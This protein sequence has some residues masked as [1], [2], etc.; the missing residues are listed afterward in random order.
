M[1]VVQIDVDKFLQRRKRIP[2]KKVLE[3]RGYKFTAV[4]MDGV[5]M[6]IERLLNSYEAFKLG[7][8][9]SHYIR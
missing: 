5:P 3:M 6:I 1:Q 7:V 9:I 8:E 4:T 2:T